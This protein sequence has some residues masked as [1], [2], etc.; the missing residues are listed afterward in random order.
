MGHLRTLFAVALA[1]GI[2]VGCTLDWELGPLGPGFVEHVIYPAGT[3]L[4]FPGLA[5]P[6]PASAGFEVPS[7]GGVLVGAANVDHTSLDLGWCRAGLCVTSCWNIP[8]NFTFSGPA[9]S[10][11]VHVKLAPGQYYWGAYCVDW[12]NVTFTQ[13]LEIVTP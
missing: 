11:S 6:G 9:W 8:G 12:G 4:R 1:V 2:S 13:P 7:G 5:F 10:Y 3:T